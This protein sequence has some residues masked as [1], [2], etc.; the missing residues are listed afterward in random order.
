MPSQSESFDTSAVEPWWR[1]ENPDDAAQQAYSVATS[2]ETDQK[3]RKH[4]ALLSVHLYQSRGVQPGVVTGNPVTS[5]LG[6]SD[7]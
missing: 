2:L 4:R 3:W 7:L 5:V 1:R 6:S